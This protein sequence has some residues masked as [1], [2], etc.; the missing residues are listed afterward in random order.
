MRKSVRFFALLSAAVLLCGCGAKRENV[1]LSIWTSQ[2]TY[3]LVNEELEDFKAEYADEA[4][5]TFN[6]SVESEDSC[7]KMV[8]SDPD[9]AADIFT[10]ADNQLN[11]MLEN[12]LI[13][14]ITVNGDQ[15]ISAVGG[16]SSGAASAAMRNGNLYACPLTAGNSYFLY[17][18]A[19][20]F[21][22]DDLK[23]LD[24]ILDAAAAS[25]KKFTMDYS[26]GWYIYSFFKGAGLDVYKTDDGK[27]F[28]NWNA[29]NTK[30]T[31]VDVAEAML[32][33]A[34]HPGFSNLNDEGFVSG[35]KDGTV[36][37]GINGAWNADTVKAAWGD[38][39][40]AIKLPTYTVAGDQ[41]QMASFAG[42]KLVSVNSRCEYPEWA[43][44]VAEYLTSEKS[45]LERFAVT[46]ECPANIAAASNEAVQSAP[47]V[48]ALAEQSVY[49]NT[50]NVSDSFWDA[51][52]KFGISIASGNEGNRDLQ[53]LLDE[54][55]TAITEQ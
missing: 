17:Y 14:E 4:D 48:K 44:R 21:S 36:I 29:T 54:T 49:G 26:S 19:A 35:V 30:Y 47:A 55:V 51:S 34:S 13:A 10:Y 42:Y 18:N 28:C 11:M 43:M 40:A 33:V 6:V 8:V 12:D 2:D 52:G 39:Y 22:P 38:D 53:E 20:Y 23:T 16:E 27:N 46:G 15:V 7:G 5:F 9:A 31:G 50:Q 45:Q 37:A 32:S 41:V 1:T 24:G 3:D 25:G